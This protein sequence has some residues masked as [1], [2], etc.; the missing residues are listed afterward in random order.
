EIDAAAKL[1]LQAFR[2]HR[3][4]RAEV[5]I[6]VEVDRQRRFLLRP[7]ARL[8]GDHH[9]V[10]QLRNAVALDLEMAAVG[11]QL[12]RERKPLAVE[13]RF[14]LAGSHEAQVRALQQPEV[15]RLPGELGIALGEAQ[16]QRAGGGEASFARLDAEALALQRVAL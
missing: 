16:R 15:A 12:A 3:K 13:A 4:V 7:G 5:E 10:A 6:D 1:A 8:P 11:A 9:V 14:A 2:M